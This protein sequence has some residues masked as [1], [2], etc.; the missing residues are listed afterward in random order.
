M[1]NKPANRI[2]RIFDHVLTIGAA[3]S[4]VILVFVMLSIAI[5]VALRYSLN[6]SLEWAVEVSEY[7][8]VGLTFFAA[9]WVLKRGGHVRMDQLFNTL[10]TRTQNILNAITSFLS[11]IACLI[12]VWYGIRVTLDHI[13]TGDRYYTTLEAPKWPVSAIIVVGFLLLLFQF[14]RRIRGYLA[15]WKASSN[16]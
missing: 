10:G 6:Q 12:L 16:R 3:L 1:R 9:A 5:D 4:G 13:Q 11:A 15:D 8:L 2:S 7:L 14:L